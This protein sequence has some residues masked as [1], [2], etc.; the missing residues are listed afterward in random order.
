[1]KL[2]RAFGRWYTA[3]RRRARRGYD[4]HRRRVARL[5][6][7]TPVEVLRLQRPDYTPSERLRAAVRRLL[8]ED[9]QQRRQLA[10][11]GARGA[12]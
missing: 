11:R 5:L 7:C 6:G 1:M 2:S 12:A 4:A 8:R 9:G 3:T 10:L